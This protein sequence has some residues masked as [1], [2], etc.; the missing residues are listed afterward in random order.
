[1]DE[2]LKL[3][4]PNICTKEYISFEDLARI[5]KIE[6]MFASAEDYYKKAI[7]YSDLAY[8]DNSNSLRLRDDLARLLREAANTQT[9][10]VLSP[11]LGFQDLA[12]VILREQCRW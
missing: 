9:N 3:K 12:E 6:G 1:L 5:C 11:S 7:S 2:W 10:E 8:R 4:G